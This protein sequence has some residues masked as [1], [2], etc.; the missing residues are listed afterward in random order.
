MVVLLTEGPEAEKNKRGIYVHNQIFTQLRR[1]CNQFQFQR[2]TSTVL[3]SNF[4][5]QREDKKFDISGFHMSQI[6]GNKPT[7]QK[8]SSAKSGILQKLTREEEEFLKKQ[9]LSSS[10]LIVSK[11]NLEVYMASY[12]DKNW[13]KNESLTL[14][15]T[16]NHSKKSRLLCSMNQFINNHDYNVKYREEETKQWMKEEEEWLENDV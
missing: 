16:I 8:N 1:N 3:P 13:Y 15:G 9:K 11:K 6:S 2:D 10:Q 12:S 5:P 4:H 14:T 7:A